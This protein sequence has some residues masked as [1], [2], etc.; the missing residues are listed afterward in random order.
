MSE[1]QV[2][3]FRIGRDDLR[4]VEV[5]ATAKEAWKQMREPGTVAHANALAR[6]IDPQTLPKQLDR[7][8]ELRPNGAGISSVDLIVTIAS[9]VG[10]KAGLDLWKYVALAHI[11]DRWGDHALKEM[12]A[13]KRSAARKK[14]TR[15]KKTQAARLA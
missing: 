14:P 9:S 3:C 6:G 12:R 8:I 5:Q 7:V 13:A 2:L 11:R 4:I 15:K 1:K 10:A